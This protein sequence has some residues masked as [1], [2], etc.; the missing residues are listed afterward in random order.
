MIW[1]KNYNIE[2][3]LFIITSGHLY[4]TLWHIETKGENEIECKIGDCSDAENIK[5]ISLLQLYSHLWHFLKRKNS[6][7]PYLRG[8]KEF[9]FSLKNAYVELFWS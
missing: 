5:T 3:G 7:S 4:F 9:Y 6:L 1:W 2:N 8:F